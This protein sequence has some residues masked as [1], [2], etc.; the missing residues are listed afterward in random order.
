MA[1]L[2]SLSDDDEE[3]SCP[4]CV[5]LLD[6]TDKNFFPCPCGYQV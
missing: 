3:E 2:L 6:V 4:L 1:A 5:E